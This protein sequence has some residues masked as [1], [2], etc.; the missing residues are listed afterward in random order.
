MQ[1][2]S[3]C[4]ICTEKCKNEL[5]GLLLSLSI[6]HINATIYIM[7]DT[8]TKEHIMN[9]YIPPLNIVWF[10]ELDKYTH[11]TRADM[12]RMGIFKEFLYSK[13]HFVDQAFFCIFIKI[14]LVRYVFNPQLFFILHPPLIH[15]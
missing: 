11:V 8:P 7:S 10:V 13:S 1:P 6:H 14:L 15:N 4:T 2:S 5:S 3:F 9:D 12:E